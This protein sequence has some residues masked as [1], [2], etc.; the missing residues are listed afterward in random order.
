M[1]ANLV[2]KASKTLIFTEPF[3]GL[4]LV[5]LNKVYREDIPTAGVSKHGIGAQLAINPKFFDDLSDKHRIGLLKHELLHISFGHLLTRERYDDKKLFN[6]AADIEINQ[7]MDVIGITLVTLYK[8]LPLANSAYQSVNELNYHKI[9]VNS[10][11]KNLL[12]NEISKKYTHKNSIPRKINQ[13]EFKNVSF[14]YDQRGDFKLNKVNLNFKINHITGINGVSGAGKTTILNILTGLLKPIS[15]DI[16]IN[17][18]KENIFDNYDWFKKISYVSQNVNIF[19]D[20]IY[21]N[22]S[23][24]FEKKETFINK[25]YID[26]ILR[27]LNLSKFLTKKII[28]DEFGKT[29][30]GG[31]LQRIAIARALFKNSEIIIFDE[32]T[33]NLDK[34]NEELLLKTIKELKKNKIIV[35]ISHNKNSLKICDD[36]IHI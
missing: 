19:N 27:N 14:K 6:I 15:G 35:L 32:P 16:F 23:Y 33:R 2:S 7:Y 20:T 34:V 8:L 9:I 36:L 11:I 4:F 24:N 13:I 29:I 21:K 18:K 30:S 10:L 17:K 12:N 3:Y 25:K 22:I 1:V 26:K 28:L 31:Q 5:G